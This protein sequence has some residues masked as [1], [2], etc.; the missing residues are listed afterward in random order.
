MNSTAYFECARLLQHHLFDFHDVDWLNETRL[1]GTAVLL[2]SIV[3]SGI[4]LL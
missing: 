1:V 4:T 2:A 3:Y